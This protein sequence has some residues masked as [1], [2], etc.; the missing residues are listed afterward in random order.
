[1]KRA[2]IYTRVSTDEQAEKGYSI[3]TQLDRCRRYAEK[4]GYQ[5]IDEPT[6]DI[7][8]MVNLNDRP[9]GK[10]LLSLI[11]S[12]DVEV[13]IV[14]RLD[15]LSRDLVE[16]QVVARMIDDYDVVLHVEDL[17]AIQDDPMG[18]F[19]LFMFGFK[20][21]G[22]HKDITERTL[23]GK[24]QKA[25]GDEKKNLP[26]KPVMT[27]YPPYGYKKDGK[28]DLAK[29]FIFEPHAQVVCLIF[30]WYVNGDGNNGPLSLNAIAS[31]LDDAGIQPPDY[32]KNKAAQQWIPATIMGILKNPIYTGVT[33]Y[34][35]SKMVGRRKNKKRVK[36][37]PDTWIEIPVP[38]LEIVS[39]TL[40]DAAQIRG[41]RNLERSLRN[42]SKQHPYLLTG[43]FRCGACNSAMAGTT[44]MP[45]GYLASN[46][47]CGNHWRKRNE[48]GC[49]NSGKTITAN[50]AE[51]VVWE[52]VTGLIND[53]LAL[54]EGLRRMAEKRE[55]ET[56]PR[57]K[58]IKMVVKE[59][60]KLNDKIGRLVNNLADE[61]DT[62]MGAAIKTQ[63]K[64]FAQQKDAFEEERQFLE[65]ELSKQTITAEYEQRVIDRVH[66]IRTKLNNPTFGQKRE[67]LDDL[68]VRV[69]FYDNDE[70][71]RLWVAC[72]IKPDGDTITLYPS[73][74][75]F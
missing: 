44:N 29:M 36:Q 51:P 23:R 38:E 50:K 45:H 69:I 27:G 67:I 25:N 15:R 65:V 16:M 48:I 20:A 68:D 71:R 8:G 61:E 32:R 49:A 14:Y 7:S 17:G 63:L 47:R 26:P 2:A 12:G 64:M 55:Q 18:S 10:R 5:I 70:G 31:K 57:Q 24:Y 54:R 37:P 58:R 34:G 56:A 39:R 21:Q 59:L 30:E 74:E 33:H 6:D 9:G 40:F 52:W 60:E 41:K 43:H 72:G 42:Q 19:S 11:E 73:S 35:K 1:M 4:I 22:E 13:V 46:Y 3:S 66:K 62:T 53:D 28:R 75:F